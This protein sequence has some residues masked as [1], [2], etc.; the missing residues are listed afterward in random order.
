M[1]GV[2]WSFLQTNPQGSAPFPWERCFDLVSDTLYY[3]NIIN[4][5]TVVDLRR[6]VDIGDSLY[7]KCDLWNN[8]TE[9]ADMNR[10]NHHHYYHL[11][12]ES[13]IIG[14]L[15]RARCCGSYFYLVMPENTFFCSNCDAFINYQGS[16][17]A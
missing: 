6:K 17:T 1:F 8:V 14:P 4:G 2:L 13:D 12:T 15:I 3:K 5:I 10:N 11:L 9:L 7:H 16:P